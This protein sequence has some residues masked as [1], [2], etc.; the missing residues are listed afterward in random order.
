MHRS[1][2]LILLLALLTGPAAAQALVSLETDVSDGLRIRSFNGFQQPGYPMPLVSF[3]L[4]GQPATSIDAIVSDGAATINGQLSIELTDVTFEDGIGRARIHFRNVGNDTLTLANIVPVGASDKHVYI[5]AYGDS[6]LSRTHLFRPGYAP[7]NVIVPDN[8]WELGWSAINVDNG[9]SIAALARRDNHSL[10]NGARQRFATILYPGGSVTYNLWLEAYIGT[11]QEGLRRT[12]QERMLYDVEPGTFNDSLLQ[13]SD[14]HWMRHAYTGHFVSVWMDYFYDRDQGRYTY[15]DFAESLKQLYGGDDFLLIWHQFPVLGLDQRNQY[16]LLRAMPGGLERIRDLVGFSNRRGTGVLVGYNPWDLPAGERQLFNSTRS[17]DHLEGLAD[18]TRRTGMRGIMFDT[19]SESYPEF[20]RAMDAVTDSFV[21]F[22]E[23]MPVPRSM[24]HA[25]VGRVHAALSHPP[26]LNL[27]KFIR[28]DFAILNQV[29][30]KHEPVYREYATSFF[31]GYGVEMHLYVPPGTP[32]LVDLYRYLGQT[33]RILRESTDLFTTGRYTPLMPTA[34]D[35]VW[36]NRWEGD[37]KTVYTIYSERPEGC[38]G[39]L[40]EVHPEEGFHFVD[41]W[42]S[43]ELVPRRVGAKWVIDANIASFPDS[44]LNTDNEGRNGAIARL[45]EILDVRFDGRSLAIRTDEGASIRI[46]DGHPA[47]GRTP[48]ELDAGRQD[49]NLS[50]AGLGDARVLVVQLIDESQQ[51]MDQ[52]VILRDPSGFDTPTA[53]RPLAPWRPFSDAPVLIS[54]SSRTPTAGGPPQ[55][56]V[57]VPAG[58]FTFDAEHIGNWM[59]PHPL[60]E[61][62]QEFQMPSFW[63]DRHPVTNADFK[64]FLDET[65]YRPIDDEQFLAHWDEG[66]IPTGTENHPVVFVSMEDAEAYAA[67]AGK[68]LPTERE[69]QYA[70]QAG[71]GRLYPWG[72]EADT[73]GVRANPGN[74]I[75]DPVGAYPQG[76]NPL[77][78]QDLVGSVW[79]MTADVYRSGTIRFGIL[80]GGSYFTPLS[81]WWYVTGGALPLIN[82]QQQL[83]VSPG[84]ERAATV[85]FRL[86]IDE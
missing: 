66:G 19:R 85:G 14:Q 6:R 51:L 34:I 75:P 4:N 62:G 33:T 78:I 30:I 12:F 80:K 70:A 10:E 18:I 49:L 38:S 3:D 74:G 69:W 1:A 59:I 20:Q 67:W 21:I 16:D 27:N 48:V 72:D 47:Y 81:S 61:I 2:I 54:S 5:T 50:R 55:G 13:R 73:L 7:V 57:H 63:I 52:R 32:W 36:V 82:R 68:R 83:R 37:R 9:N 25:V 86:V 56:M 58:R 41:L 17:E 43:R 23:G 8:A 26:M 71:D 46:W 77:G 44:L 28:P 65:S 79:Q 29:E 53:N 42:N 60:E 84:Y 45:P 15:E 31:N 22:P 39:P 35:S 24:Q 40:F 64:V 11:W 76:A